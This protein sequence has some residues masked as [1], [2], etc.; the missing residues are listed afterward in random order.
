MTIW[1]F[2][3]LVGIAG[4]LGGVLNALLSQEGLTLPKTERVDGYCVVRLGAF[5][6]ILIGLAAALVFWGLYS[7][8]SNSSILDVA[9]NAGITIGSLVAAFLAGVGGARVIA[10]EIDKHLLN[11]AAEAAARAPSNVQAAEQMRHAAP[12][13]VLRIATAMEPPA[14]LAPANVQVAPQI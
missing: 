3:V 5:G 6:N 14:P 13:D 2:A 12:V 8:F 9:P 11:T 1:M 10:N 4:M 7:P